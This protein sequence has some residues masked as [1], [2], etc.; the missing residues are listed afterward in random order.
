MFLTHLYN[1]QP[2]KYY[3]FKYKQLTSVSY[4]QFLTF[5][6]SISFIIKYQKNSYYKLIS[7]IRWYGNALYSK[8]N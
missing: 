6:Y 4:T 1:V 3:D 5:K 2:K 8:Q 7:P